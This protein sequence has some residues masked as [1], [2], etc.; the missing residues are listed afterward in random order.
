MR[1][2]SGVRLHND[3]RAE[4]QLDGSIIRLG[5]NTGFSFLN[6]GDTVTQVRLTEG[7]LDIH[8]RRMDR[9]EAYEV[10]TPNLAFSI[11]DEGD[12]M[13]IVAFRNVTEVLTM[14]PPD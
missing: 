1:H 11:Y 12:R 6:L 5:R 13:R 4:L 3:G 10:D 2:F 7:T 8:V 9:D 14:T